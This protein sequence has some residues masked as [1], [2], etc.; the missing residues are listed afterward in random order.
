[1]DSRAGIR[2]WT[3]FLVLGEGAIAFLTAR[4][5]GLPIGWAVFG[6]VIAATLTGLWGYAVLHTRAPPE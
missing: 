6:F 5:A 4:Y 2:F 3:V 1:M